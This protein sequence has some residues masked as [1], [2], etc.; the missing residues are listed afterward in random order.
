[1]ESNWPSNAAWPPPSSCFSWAE[2]GA[3]KLVFY[4]LE[5]GQSSS[6]PYWSSTT[7]TDSTTPR[8][9]QEQNP[10][11]L[12][13]CSQSSSARL[14]KT[15]DFQTLKRHQNH[16]N[17][18]H[19]ILCKCSLNYFWREN[20]NMCKVIKYCAEQMCFLKVFSKDVFENTFGFTSRV[21]TLEMYSK[22][23][24]WNTLSLYAL[25][26]VGQTWK[27]W[28]VVNLYYIIRVWSE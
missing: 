14:S 1:M 22:Y 3:C 21:D 12:Y 24:R 10:L 9:F 15:G 26:R 11:S 23:R 19:H 13:I 7:T 25:N 17:T 28:F 20:T 16:E 27:T 2:K 4:V 8:N 6:K 18:L 5:T